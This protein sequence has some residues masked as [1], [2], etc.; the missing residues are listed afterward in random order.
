MTTVTKTPVTLITATAN[1]GT[2]GSTKGAPSVTSG[3]IDLGGAD[4]GDIGL[5]ILNGTAPGAAGT[6]QVQWSHDAGT[7]VYDYGPPLGGDLSTFN[8]SSLAGL[9]TATI[10]V[11]PGIRYVRIIGYGN[12]TNAVTFGATFSG[13]TRA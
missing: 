2:A 9:T 1:N 7:T 6:L 8:S 11:D 4:G 5:S 3:W 10:W 12:T 13:V